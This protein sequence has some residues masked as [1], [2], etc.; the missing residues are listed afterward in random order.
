M[1]SWI[2]TSLSQ[3]GFNRFSRFCTAR[4]TMRAKHTNTH[5]PRVRQT[6]VAVGRIYAMHAIVEP[7]THAQ[8]L[9]RW[10]SCTSL[11][12][13]FRPHRIA[14]TRPIA[15]YVARFVIC[16]SVLLG[17]PVSLAETTEPQV[18]WFASGFEWAQR[19]E[20]DS[21]H[22]M[23]KSPTTKGRKNVERSYQK[24]WKTGSGQTE[25]SLAVV[26]A[27]S[28]THEYTKVAFLA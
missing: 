27:P 18:S 5:R 22:V 20:C 16:Q 9:T 24:T 7:R 13:T 10:V 12:A 21:N 19:T 8:N 11:D 1:V 4:I 14:Y 6:R 26:L 3:S 25:L 28:R 17:I 23:Q 2:H 15:T